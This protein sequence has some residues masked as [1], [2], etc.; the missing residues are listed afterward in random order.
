[1]PPK[2]VGQPR[3]SAAADVP[4]TG[5]A[6]E[7]VFAW[8]LFKRAGDQIMVLAVEISAGSF[9]LRFD[10]EGA[11]RETFTATSEKE[12]GIGDLS[13]GLHTARIVALA[14][15]STLGLVEAHVSGK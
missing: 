10:A 14:T 9:G 11:D 13:V 6:G 3:F 7:D 12:V 5:N 2:P 15:T 4:L 1:M 8:Q